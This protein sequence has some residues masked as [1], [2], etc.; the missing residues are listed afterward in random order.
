MQD[1]NDAN[2]VA[3]IKNFLEYSPTYAESTATN[4]LFYLDTDYML[5]NDLHK[6]IT[7]RGLPFEKYFL[8]PLVK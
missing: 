6:P 2:H 5:K 8:V 3:N 1:C 7:I 4:E